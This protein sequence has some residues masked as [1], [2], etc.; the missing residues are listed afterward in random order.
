M[1]RWRLSDAKARLRELVRCAENQGPQEI[2][3][4]GRPAAVLLSKADFDR[5]VKQKKPTFVEFLRR[6]PLV[7]VDLVV[8]RDRS[9]T[10]TLKL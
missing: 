2:T 8:H 9:R 5:L 3:V 10:R 7:G 4:R 6:S 1:A